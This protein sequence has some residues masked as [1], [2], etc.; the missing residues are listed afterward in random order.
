MSD[1]RDAPLR[2]TYFGGLGSLIKPTDDNLVLAVVR[3]P[4]EFVN[5]V[6]DRTVPAVAPPTNLLD[7]YKRVEEA[8]ESDD[9]PN[10]SGVAWRSVGFGRRYREHLEQPGQQQVIETLRDKARETR[11]WL[12]CYEK[13]PQWCHRR[14]LADELATDD[15]AV[16]HH[17]E[18]STEIDAESGR[19]DARLT[20]FGGTE[21]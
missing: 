20:E 16:A 21:Q 7:A 11:V 5:D 2:T 6:A 13:N 12:V 10:P 18:P 4:H 8:A 9:L 17:P 19:R 14:L 15:L 1:E 3:N